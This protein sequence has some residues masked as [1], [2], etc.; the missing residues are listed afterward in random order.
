MG[1]AAPTRP[2]PLDLRITAG[3]PHPW[4]LAQADSADVVRGSSDDLDDLPA[5]AAENLWLLLR[6]LDTGFQ[7]TADEGIAG[8][9]TL[10]R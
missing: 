1:R 7:R 10:E 9:R 8:S 4:R 2:P 6:P 5:C 3:F